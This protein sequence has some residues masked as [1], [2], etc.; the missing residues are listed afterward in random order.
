MSAPCPL[1]AS[2]TRFSGVP[3]IR[4]EQDRLGSRYG[5][6]EVEGEAIYPRR[7]RRCVT[8]VWTV[9]AGSVLVLG[10]PP[11]GPLARWERCWRRPGPAA[12]LPSPSAGR[13]AQ[14]VPLASRVRQKAA[15]HSQRVCERGR[16]AAASCCTHTCSKQKAA[17]ASAQ[18][19]AR[20]APA[21]VDTCSEDAAEATASVCRR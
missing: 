3:F 9:A 15:M 5:G 17:H 2:L 6:T 20:R 21:G 8:E 13:R 12:L 4:Y 7:I 14:R 11:E 19:S 16:G 18:V 1:I 10:A